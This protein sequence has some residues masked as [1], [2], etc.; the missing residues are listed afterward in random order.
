MSDLRSAMTMLVAACPLLGGIARGEQTAESSSGRW[1]SA[2]DIKLG[3]QIF[4][5]NCAACHGAQTQGETLRVPPLNGRGHSTHHRLDY[6]L[7]QVKNGS[8]AKGGQMPPFGALLSESER[9]ASV[10]WVQSLWPE[11]AYRSW[12]QMHRGNRH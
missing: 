8:L 9:R 4:A 3:Q 7:E 5:S 10:A 1:Y 2:E 6:L 12:Q 11:D